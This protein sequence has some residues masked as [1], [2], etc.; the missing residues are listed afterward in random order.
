[1]RDDPLQVSV[2]QCDR[3]GLVVRVLL[4]DELGHAG[5]E[6]V[7][8]DVAVAQQRLRRSSSRSRNAAAAAVRNVGTSFA[9]LVISPVCIPRRQVD[10]VR[11]EVEQVLRIV[12]DA[13]D[14]LDDRHVD[15]DRRRVDRTED[16]RMHDELA[17][18]LALRGFTPWSV[19]RSSAPTSWGERSPRSADIA[20]S[21][22]C[23]SSTI[24]RWRVASMRSRRSA[25][26]S[27]RNLNAIVVPFGPA[28]RRAVIGHGIRKTPRRGTSRNRPTR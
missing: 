14:V 19:A 6:A 11:C 26:P 10:T 13:L 15:E 25:S 22:A 24:I 7:E 4:L 12:A 3:D 8:Q 2:C 28:P 17:T 27:L 23:R 9:R 16:A 5:V 20:S 1:V 21:N 18:D